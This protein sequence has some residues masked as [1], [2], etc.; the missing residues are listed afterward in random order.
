MTLEQTKVSPTVKKKKNN[1]KLQ[2]ASSSGSLLIFPQKTFLM[3]TIQ[4]A[5][6]SIETYHSLM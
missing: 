2:T 3:V 6:A 4:S 5:K 1:N